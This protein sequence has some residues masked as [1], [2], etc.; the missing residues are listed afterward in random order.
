[1][2]TERI[3]AL[4][5]WHRVFPGKKVTGGPNSII[6]RAALGK[7]RAHAEML[8]KQNSVEKIELTSCP[9]PAEF[10]NGRAMIANWHS[11]DFSAQVEQDGRVE[12]WIAVGISFEQDDIQALAQN[13]ETGGVSLH[14]KKLGGQPKSGH[15][16]KYDWAKAVGTVI[17]Q[18]V[19]SSSW[20]PR[21]QGEVKAKLADW[22]D[23]ENQTPDEK[24]LKHYARWLFGEFQ[25]HESKAE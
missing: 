17:F 11:G 5:A 15:P 25:K 12:E 2:S 23:K 3:S 20:Q 16:G 8:I 19:D 9:I 22:F 21:S 24:Q 14:P 18:W 10:W 1:M 4:D 13:T 6:R 7:V